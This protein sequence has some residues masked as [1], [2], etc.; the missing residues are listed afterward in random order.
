MTKLKLGAIEDDKPV[1]LTVE[2]PAQIHRDLLAYAQ[3]LG[4]LIVHSS[5]ITM[6]PLGKPQLVASY[7]PKRGPADPNGRFLPS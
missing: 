7:T 2:L 5:A 4:R 3:V 1:K 6:P